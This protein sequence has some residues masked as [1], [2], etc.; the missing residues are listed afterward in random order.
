MHKKQNRLN[1]KTLTLIVLLIGVSCISIG[2][3]AF[4]STLNIR[5]STTV[6]P[7]ESSF[8]VYISG[9]K[10]SISYLTANFSASYP[11]ADHA[12]SGSSAHIIR[13]S[14]NHSSISDINVIFTYPG[15]TTAWTVFIHNQNNYDVYY[16]FTQTS[17]N[18]KCVAGEGTTDALVQKACSCISNNLLRKNTETNKFENIDSSKLKISKNSVEEIR[19]QIKY[20]YC[21]NQADGPFDIEIGDYEITTTSAP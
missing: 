10:T 20:N 18:L 19:L 13:D 16:S 5:S 12:P 1:R 21:S 8:K 14:A 3:A 11:D 9:S 7:D 15:Q 2:L 4:S 17:P 6:S